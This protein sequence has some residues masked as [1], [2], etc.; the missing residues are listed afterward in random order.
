[1]FHV[2]V[3]AQAS[4][5]LDWVKQG[6]DEFVDPAHRSNASL[7]SHSHCG[8]T[9]K[10]DCSTSSV[11]FKFG[12]SNDRRI[13]GLHL[14]EAT[15]LTLTDLQLLIDGVEVQKYRQFKRFRGV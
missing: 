5:N 1:M 11:K 2:R 12:T 15:A 4:L 9:A 10:N 14:G 8:S 6:V 7:F 3:Q 13:G